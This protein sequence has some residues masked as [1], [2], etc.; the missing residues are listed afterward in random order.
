MCPSNNGLTMI[1]TA[2][3]LLTSGSTLTPDSHED[4]DDTDAKETEN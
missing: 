1:K 2:G 3:P 4:A